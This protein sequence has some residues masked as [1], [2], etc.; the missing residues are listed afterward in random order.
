MR[1]NSGQVRHDNAKHN[2]DHHGDHGD[3]HGH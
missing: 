3:D 2:A 1:G